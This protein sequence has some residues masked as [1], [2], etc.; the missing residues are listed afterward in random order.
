MNT[1]LPHFLIIGAMKSGTTSLYNDL[2]TSDDFYLPEDKEPGVLV[3]SH[4]KEEVITRY[5]KHFESAIPHQIR[6]DGSTYYTMQPLFPDVSRLAK[7]ACG[8]NLKLVAILRDPVERLVSHLY[9]DYAAGR[10]T[11]LSV[12]KAIAN[13]ERYLAFSDYPRQL[14]PWVAAFGQKQICVFSLRHYI[15]NRLETVCSVAS[16][17]GTDPQKIELCSTISNQKGSTRR[18]LLSENMMSVYRERL[19]R[20]TPAFVQQ[21]GINLL[22]KPV[23]SMP[24]IEFPSEIKLSL[25]SRFADSEAS[26]CNL[27]GQSIKF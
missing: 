2:K 12:E 11:H 26:L 1:K 9:H 4:S 15:S 10:L 19:K 16:F 18:L 27:L 5:S 13:D 22:T 17:L 14:K 21:V 25:R 20:L 8:G 24:E 7:E 6:G 3:K 23:Q